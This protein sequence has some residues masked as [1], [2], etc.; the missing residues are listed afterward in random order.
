MKS[1]FICSL[2]INPVRAAS[3][4]TIM[5]TVARH[6]GSIRA[7]EGVTE[8]GVAPSKDGGRAE[9]QETLYSV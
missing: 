5:A 7:K 4:I 3:K 2:G 8:S 9:L 1:F 6:T